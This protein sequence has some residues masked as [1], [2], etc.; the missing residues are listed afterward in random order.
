MKSNKLLTFDEISTVLIDQ[1]L[2]YKEISKE[3]TERGKLYRNNLG[4]E[5]I[6]LK[7]NDKPFNIVFKQDDYDVIVETKGISINLSD[8]YDEQGLIKSGFVKRKF[9]KPGIPIE[10]DDSDSFKALLRKISGFAVQKNSI[11]KI[12]DDISNSSEFELNESGDK[13][14]KR[15]VEETNNCI[16]DIT[17]QA[18]KTRRGQKSFRNALLQIFEGKCCI[19]GCE[20]VD[21]LEAAHI[22]PHTEETNYHITNG[23]LLRADIH[24]LFDLGLIQINKYGIV[25][26]SERLKGSNY[27]EYSELNISNKLHEDTLSNLRCREL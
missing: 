8:R 21:V 11:S 16:D 5:F 12:N 25:S 14:T 15:K 27:D 6:V 18:I 20:V 2:T 10:I 4:L 9:N 7:K 22:I 23:L 24:T 19:T 26:I 1:E 3:C 17:F 13:D